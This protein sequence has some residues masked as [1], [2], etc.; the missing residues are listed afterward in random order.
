M[1]KQ[2][3][4]IVLLFPLLVLGQSADQNYVKTTTYK[5]PIT[6]P[7]FGVPAEDVAD[8]QITYFDGLGRPIQQRAHRQSGTGKDVV[9]PI[10]YDAYG[11]QVKEYLPYPTTTAPQAYDANAITGQSSYYSTPA[12]LGQPY[13]ETTTNP[14]SEKL[15]EASP[16]NRVLK[17]AAPGNDWVMGSNHEVKAEYHTN[18]AA[19]AVRYFK[20]SATWDGNLYNSTL[21]IAG[22][23]NY[24]AGELFKNTT[25]DENNIQT[26][27][28]KDK[29]GR[30]ILKR[31]YNNAVPHDTYYVYDRYN[32]LG[33]V[34]PPMADGIISPTVLDGVC[35]QYKYDS[36]NRLVEKKLPGKQWEYIVYDKLDRVVATGPAYSPFGDGAPG[37][38]MTKYDAFNRVA[39]TAWLEAGRPYYLTS[40]GRNIYQLE[41]ANQTLLNEAKNSGTTING[42]TFHYTSLAVPKLGYHVLQVNYYDDYNFP[43]APSNFT[44]TATAAVYYNNTTLQPKGMPT[45]SWTRALQGVNA[46][47][48]ETVYMLYDLKSRVVQNHATSYQG[49]FTRSELQYDFAGKILKNITTHN[50]EGTAAAITTAETFE[51]TN[52]SRL[53]RHKH[54]VNALAEEILSENSYDERGQL[55]QK[56]IGGTGS[57][58]QYVDYDYTVRGWLK[59]INSAEVRGIPQDLFSYKINYTTVEH[60][61]WGTIPKLYNGNITETFWKTSSDGIWRKYGYAYDGLN[62]F[63]QS[64]Y[65][66]PNEANPVTNSYSEGMDYDKNGNTTILI[67]FGG[68]DSAPLQMIDELHY[69][70]DANSPNRLMKVKDNT[71]SPQG[72]KDSPT[73][74]D[75]YTYDANGN[76]TLDNNKGITA[77]S[78]NHLNLP[79]KIVFGSE[80]QK[81]EYLYD[82]AGGK[83][84]KITTDNTVIRKTSYRDGFQY[85]EGELGFFPTAEGYV[86]RNVVKNRVQFN[87]I[88]N[89]T[90]HLGNVRVS[91]TK[92]PLTTS[93]KIVEEN[94]YYPFGLKHANYNSD[95]LAFQPNAQ[96]AIILDAFVDPIPLDNYLNYEYKYNG[97]ELQREFGLNM[98]DYG[99][100]NYDPAIGRWMNMDPLA[101]NHHENNPYMY[102][103]NNPIIFVDPDGMD[104]TLT[105]E[106]AQDFARG[107]QRQLSETEASQNFG[108]DPPKKEKPGII[109]QFL[110]VIP[111]LG[112]T[113]ESSDK[114]EEGDYWGSAASFGMGI[115]DLFTLGAANKYKTGTAGVV[116]GTEEILA[117]N[118][119]KATTTGLA[120]TGRKFSKHSLERLAERGVTVDMAELAIKKGQ[121][122]YDPLNKSVN[123]ILSKGFVSGK[124]LLVGTNPVTG[125][126]T[127]VIR[128]S[129]NLVKTRMVPIK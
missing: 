105:G 94:H 45:G 28:F 115:M 79:V 77:I 29:E 62:R 19:D 126:I 51:Y 38:L 33:Y 53:L 89:Y 59:A 42:I 6:L 18:T 101:E 86:R 119:T 103:N 95:Q 93:A 7:S 69:T 64:W 90:D 4:L 114:I 36:R 48:G 12:G 65:Q 49:G 97:K 81:I 60:D 24:A 50:I 92:D 35:Y 23:S 96:D 52:Q 72:F 9:T 70:Y 66:R 74:T 83:L 98:Y 128:S 125:E 108:E 117:T 21:T 109:K 68:Q 110:L 124:S 63:I 123:Y 85:M 40:A 34:I 32:N 129:K 58:L 55:L 102:A 111:V 82:A 8:I 121:K 116:I 106:A 25:R 16:L 5:K 122:F 113:I 14:Y 11:R 10:F 1:K 71:N 22:T 41:H 44:A 76:M 78:Y 61:L 54:Q 118:A 26:E 99:A 13:F 27:E 120:T 87:Y 100:R 15:F 31:G 39:Y 30:V 107:L 112:P 91:Y 2:Y 75:D 37:W 17:Q 73:D 46:T 43:G 80:S 3:L 20:A 56:K 104:F 84:E 67:R 57:P 127:T 47:A 88:Y